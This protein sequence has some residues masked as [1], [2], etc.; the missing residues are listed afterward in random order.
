MPFNVTSGSTVVFT[1]VFF[2]ANGA[3][4]VP[5]SATITVTYPLSSDPLTTTSCSIGMTAVGDFFTA[6]WGSGVAALGKSSATA[7]APGITSADP[8]TLRIIS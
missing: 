8:Q 6:T 4:T 7:I 5:T 2:D 3:V 1:V